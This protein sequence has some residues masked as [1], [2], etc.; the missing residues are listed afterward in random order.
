MKTKV[1]ITT[2]HSLYNAIQIRML[3]ILI[4]INLQKGNIIPVKKL[5]ICC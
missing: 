5:L 1:M 4:K 2:D 3:I